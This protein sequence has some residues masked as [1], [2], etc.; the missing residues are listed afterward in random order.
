MPNLFLSGIYYQE[1]TQKSF[2]QPRPRFIRYYEDLHQLEKMEPID[3]NSYMTG[4]QLSYAELGDI[5]LERCAKEEVLD[6]VDLM[7]V[8]HWSY[9]FDPDYACGAY[10][11]HRYGLQ[12]KTLDVCDQGILSPFTAF[13]L[14]KNYVEHDNIT[15]AL[16]LCLDQ[17]TVPHSAS[18]QGT[19]PELTSVLGVYVTPSAFNKAGCEIVYSDVISIEN[20][21]NIIDF[22]YSLLHIFSIDLHQINWYVDRNDTELSRQIQVVFPNVTTIS[23]K[24]NSAEPIAHILRR[25][26]TP[27][28]GQTA[29]YGLIKNDVESSDYGILIVKTGS[30]E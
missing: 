5:I 21:K 9:E 7:V 6:V 27:T 18:Y 12:C 1:L 19:L 13:H 22:L 25:V 29:Y 17:T 24:V 3:S 20:K 4:A 15:N 10:F 8:T 28:A 2:K 23:Y 30:E 11:C 26:S 16:L 14:M